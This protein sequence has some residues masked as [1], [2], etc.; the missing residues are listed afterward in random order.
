MRIIYLFLLYLFVYLAVF[1]V[2]CLYF[3]FFSLFSVR[4]KSCGH[5]KYARF[6]LTDGHYY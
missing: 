5:A 6:W 1:T 2:C 3:M 4:T